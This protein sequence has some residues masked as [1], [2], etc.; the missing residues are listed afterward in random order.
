LKTIRVCV[1]ALATIVSAATAK[2]QPQR[3]A[4]QPTPAQLQQQ[5]DELKQRLAETQQTAA[6]AKLANDYAQRTEDDAKSYYDKVLATETRSLWIMG[7][8]ITVLL[9]LAARFGFTTFEKLT[10]SAIREAISQLR[11]EFAIATTQLRT[12]TAVALGTEVESL[13]KAN[14]SNMR[15]LREELVKQMSESDQLVEANTTYWMALNT[16]VAL[17]EPQATEASIAMSRNAIATYKEFKGKGSFNPQLG[18]LAVR[19]TLHLIRFLR[20]EDFP[21]SARNEL[22][23]NRELYKD[24]DPEIT[25]AF[26]KYKELLPVFQE[27]REGKLNPPS[28]PSPTQP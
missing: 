16:A 8:F 5:V 15:E 19:H 9:A 22:R 20:P 11:S 21:E 27:W 6:A 12:D 4:A 18:A 10:Q 3:P 14:T 25:E 1:L 2:P 17:S 24:L 26:L 23:A 28:M 13:K 7:I